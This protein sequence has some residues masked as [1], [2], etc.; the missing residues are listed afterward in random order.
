MAQVKAHVWYG[1]AG[2]VV[3]VGR[4]VDDAQ[5][6]PIG[7]DDHAVLETEVEEDEIADLHTTHQVD[8]A[9]QEMR[10]LGTE[11]PDPGKTTD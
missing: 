7:S 9:C 10:P 3:A 8:V 5:V 2:D 4:P 1:L 11:G 6:I